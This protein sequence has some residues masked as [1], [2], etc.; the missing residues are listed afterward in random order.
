MVLS[1][2]ARSVS[3]AS[4]CCTASIPSLASAT[5]SR[6]GVRV[7]HHPQAAAQHGGIVGEQDSRLE[8]RHGCPPSGT[9]RRTWQLDQDRELPIQSVAPINVVHARV[10]GM[11]VPATW[12][13][14]SE[15]VV[16]DGGDEET[17]VLGQRELRLAARGRWRAAFVKTSCT[18]R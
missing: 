2:I 12:W 6:D 18:A 13:G 5:T 16:K 14:Q 1:R 7:E 15:A 3:W 9:S 11:L 8:R 4:A 10:R 17:A